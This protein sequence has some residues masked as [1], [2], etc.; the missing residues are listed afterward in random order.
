MKTLAK[1]FTTPMLGLFAV[2]LVVMVLVFNIFGRWYSARVAGQEL[3]LMIDSSQSLIEGVLDRNEELNRKLTADK[4]AKLSAIRKAVNLTKYSLNTEILLVNT[5]N[6]VVYESDNTL[7]ER[8]I[9]AV[10]AVDG[11]QQLHQIRVGSNRYLVYVHPLALLRGEGKLVLVSDMS[12]MDRWLRLLNLIFLGLAGGFLILGYWLIGQLSRQI[13]GQLSQVSEMVVK[14]QDGEPM[15]QVQ[16]NCLEVQQL[17][18]GITTLSQQ[19]A[20]SEQSQ[21]QFLQNASHELRTPLMA[22]QGFAE[23]ISSGV[24]TDA[25]QTAQLIAQESVRLNGL[26]EE[27]LTLSRFEAG[28]YLPQ[29]TKQPLSELLMQVVS[30]ANGYAVMMHKELVVEGSTKVM[31]NAQA[32]L[33]MQ[34]VYN[35]VV[36]AIRYANFRVVIS[37]IEDGGQVRLVVHD[38]G[39]GVSQEELPHLFE[40]FFKG[41]HGNHGLG[42][43]IAK[44]AIEHLGG[45]IVVHNDQGAVFTV[46]L[47]VIKG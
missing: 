41:Q 11:D 31:I 35:I 29:L 30:K 20:D 15:G 38:D 7:H 10:L 37:V 17:V 6:K 8:V 25:A 47:P 18:D 36:N 4:L 42:L 44:A 26:V 24:F 9:N 45:R 22:I 1:K 19:L 3:K 2:L 21:K 13:T 12:G 27:L 23:G 28:T 33:F 32:E 14:L 40:R 5:N 43:A 34:G 46:F 16:A 39:V